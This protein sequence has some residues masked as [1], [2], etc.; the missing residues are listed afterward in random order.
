[1]ALSVTHIAAHALDKHSKE[2]A[3]AIIN[4]NLLS[5]WLKASNRLRVVDGGQTFHE[6]V[7]YSEIGGF[8]WISKD[9]EIPLTTTDTL[10]DAEY[11]IR[12]LAGPI[13]I[14][15][16]DKSMAQG[17]SQVADIVETT[18]E[19]AKSTMSNRLGA[20][21]FNDGSDT[22][23]LHGIQHLISTAAG[24]TVGGIDSGT[25]S[26]WDRTAVTTGTAGFN[27]AQAGISIMNDLMS[28]T[29]QNDH[30]W[31][32]LLVTTSAI[33]SLF[34]LSTTNV[35]RL[36]DSRV[37]KLGFRTLDFMGTP[38]GWDA[39][40]PDDNIYAI[41][42]KYMFLR[43]LSGGNFVTSDWERV[44]GQLADYATMHFYGQLTTNNRSKLGVATGI[45]G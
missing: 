17:E 43:V 1:M 20:A 41:N 15:H 4:H 32:D 29:A 6:K 33:W 10:T 31:P 22:T 34:Q 36:V 45:T 42:S 35:T 2:I 23:A 38:V 12:V 40:A 30:D 44:Q 5:A 39:N 3:D 25:Y 7:I 26:W 27:T 16:L 24:A 37:G 19:T 14:Y 9:T 28:Q 21:V 13:K 8:N 18:I 11:N